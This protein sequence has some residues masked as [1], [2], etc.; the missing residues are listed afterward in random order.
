M[1]TIFPRE[2]KFYALLTRL[3]E[4]AFRSSQQLAILFQSQ[5][6]AERTTAAANIATAKSAAKAV[7]SEITL[8]LCRSFITPFDREDIQGIADN[9]YKIPKTIEK[10]AERVALHT[11]AGNQSDFAPQVDLIQSEAIAMQS[12]MAGLTGKGSTKQVL[13]KVELLNQLEQRGDDIRAGL[14]R[15]LYKT[16]REIRD[17]LIRRDIY[18]MLEKVV[19]RFR[20]V[21]GVAL[22]IVLKHS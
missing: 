16:E 15:E 21:A 7:A 6:E 4:E 12:I 13:E 5:V 14:L 8:E 2:E 18:D 1:F 22:Q 3:S 11:L 20:D 19:D 10:I 17:L 9:L